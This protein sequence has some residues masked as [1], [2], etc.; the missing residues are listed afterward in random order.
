MNPANRYT[1]EEA[2][3]SEFF[4][5]AG[6]VNPLDLPSLSVGC[7]VGGAGLHEFGTKKLRLV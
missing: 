4:S 2:L 5:V 1:A 7:E 3:R 6:E